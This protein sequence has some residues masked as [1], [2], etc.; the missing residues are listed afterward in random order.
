MRSRR[1]IK[2]G[3]RSSD[4][5]RRARAK[6]VTRERSCVSSLSRAS[7]SRSRRAPAT[8]ARNSYTSKHLGVSSAWRMRETPV[9]RVWK[10]R[11]YFRGDAIFRTLR[12]LQN[13]LTNLHVPNSKLKQSRQSPFLDNW[14]SDMGVLRTKNSIDSQPEPGRFPN[15]KYEILRQWQWELLC[16]Y[17]RSCWKSLNGQV[18]FNFSATFP[19]I[20]LTWQ[21]SFEKLDPLRTPWRIWR[22]KWTTC[23][24]TWRN[25]CHFLARDTR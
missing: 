24:R 9:G 1:S 4:L 21:M 18:G 11:T 14:C 23:K 16:P 5:E 12:K 13:Y 17:L 15:C 8:Q 20:H 7:Y 6:S 10:L 25:L 19:V 22:R 2:P 3:A